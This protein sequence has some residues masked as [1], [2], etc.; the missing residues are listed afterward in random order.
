[1]EPEPESFSC[2]RLPPE[3]WQTVLS[4]LPQSTTPECLFVCR[5]FHDLAA[6][7]LFATVRIEFGSWKLMCG[8]DDNTPE[9]EIGRRSS[10]L[11]LRII[12]DPIFA[13]YVKHLY[14]LVFANR[15]VAFEL[16]C[17]TKAI[18]ALHNLRTFAWYTDSD[19]SE[20]AIV[21]DNEHLETLASTCVHLCEYD[22]PMDSLNELQAVKRLPATNVALYSTRREPIWDFDVTYDNYH[23]DFASLLE[24]RKGS[25]TR[26]TAPGQAVW[27]CP[28]HTLQGLT[29]LTITDARRLSNITLLFHHCERLEYLHIV[30]NDDPPDLFAAL[31]ADPAALPRLTH[32]K[33][34]TP[35]ANPAGLDALAGFLRTK[36]RLR[37]LDYSDGE[38]SD[39]E[40]MA[41]VISA[42]QSLPTLEVLGLHIALHVNG[43][44][45]FDAL[46]SAIPA[47]VTAL[48]VVLDYSDL[49]ESC[50]WIE[51]W[52]GLPMLAFAYVD[53]DRDHPMMDMLELATATRS[54][55]LVGQRSR[56]YEVQRA[57]DGVTLS[58]PWSLTKTE[59]R[60]AADFGCEDWEWLM[61]D[62]FPGR[63]Y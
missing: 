29:H 9:G 50:S 27:D 18:S 53:Y 7:L 55:K 21:P 2:G 26:L 44:A 4:H 32:F 30:L 63:D 41:P 5:L 56:F 60:T 16:C 13:S 25:L 57:E 22:L 24:A 10:C 19:P 52:T 38:A 12:T 6:R 3:M 28:I 31:A 17:L 61:R 36:K 48:S 34:Y 20:R 47:S 37:C 11:L 46:K 1:M 45:Q 33:L 23:W 58:Q 40:D 14:V 54:L 62:L 42:I 15:D 8:V 49:D 39:I 59:F 51:V 43:P 35:P